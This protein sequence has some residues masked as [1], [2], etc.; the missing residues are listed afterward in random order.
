MENKSNEINNAPS[1]YNK[2]LLVLAIFIFLSLTSC[3]LMQKNE[4]DGIQSNKSSAFSN[5]SKA[6]FVEDVQYH[7]VLR[8]AMSKRDILLCRQIKN[9]AEK[10]RCSEIME[11]YVVEGTNQTCDPECMNKKAMEKSAVT[12]GIGF[13]SNINDSVMKKGCED[14]VRKKLNSSSNYT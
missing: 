14:W 10:T 6:V 3:N 12:K 2:I 9:Q 4:M 1:Q 8:D 5:E 11:L 7:K 13:C